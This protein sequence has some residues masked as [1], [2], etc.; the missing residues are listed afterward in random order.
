MKS[1]SN[2]NCKQNNP[3][4]LDNFYKSKKNKSGVVSECK[5]CQKIR[6]KDTYT[7]NLDR[8]LT[9]AKNYRKNNP[10]KFRNGRIKS[11]YGISS[12]EYN[13]LLNKQ[14]DSCAICKIH[15]S[16]IKGSFNIDH[17]HSTGKVRGLLCHKCN[18][19][20]GLFL[21]KPEIISKA[22]DYLRKFA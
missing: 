19:G 12:E 7:N 18:K 4:S 6:S 21:D 5:E 15:V 14:N 16:E 13:L 10:E 11:L 8:S 9:Y 17:N 20:L 22:V 2:K 3:Q 1:C